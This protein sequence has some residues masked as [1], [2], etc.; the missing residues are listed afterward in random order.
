MAGAADIQVTF[1]AYDAS[2]SDY[3]ITDSASAILGDT[4][5]A[6]D[7]GV[8]T[9]NVDGP[10]GAGVGVQ[11]G[12]LEDVLQLE[13]GMS[14]D[15]IFDVEDSAANIVANADG[16][17]EARNVTV[18]DT[19]NNYVSD[20]S[21]SDAAAIEGINNSGLTTYNILDTAQNLY[22]LEITAQQVQD[23]MEAVTGFG[24][25]VT[26]AQ[27]AQYVGMVP[28][29]SLTN[30]ASN[31]NY[32][33]SDI[34]EYKAA[35][36]TDTASFDVVQAYI[37]N[38]PSSTLEEYTIT[39]DPS[40]ADISISG[41]AEVFKSSDGSGTW[42][43]RVEVGETFVAEDVTQIISEDTTAT[44][45]VS[46][47]TVATY[48]NSATVTTYQ[49]AA[50]FVTG[51]TWDA[52][53]IYTLVPAIAA[54]SDLY[55]G[56]ETEQQIETNYLSAL[57]GSITTFDEFRAVGAH[58]ENTPET[59]DA[60]QYFDTT[61]GVIDAVISNVE[62]S[63]DA[64]V[65]IGE[66]LASYATPVTFDIADDIS[67]VIGS[68][69]QTNGNFGDVRDITINDTANMAQGIQIIDGANSGTIDVNVDDTAGAI[70]NELTEVSG[71]TNLDELTSLTVT[72]GVVDVSS[73]DDLQSVAGYDSGASSYT[74]TDTA[75]AILGDTATVIDDGVSH[76][77]VAGNVGAGVGVQLGQL[78]DA[79][80]E[81]GY[82]ADI[83]FNVVDDANDIAAAL[84][85][86]T[87]G[88]MDNAASMIVSG[89][90][91]TVTEAAD[92]QGVAGYDSGASSYTITDS[93]D[94]VLTASNESSILNDGVSGVVVTDATGAGYVDALDGE[95]LSDLE[96]LLQTATNDSAA[97][98]EFRVEDDAAAIAAVL[99]G[100][101]FALD[102][103]NDLEVTGGAT[104][105]AGAADIQSSGAYDAANSDYTIT[106]TAGAILGDTA[107]AIDDGVS[108]INVAGNVG[109]GVGVQLGQLEDASFETGYSA[110]INFNVVDDAN[111]IAAALSGDTTGAMDNAASMIVS[112]GT[113][114]VTEAADIQGV[115]GYD[116]GASSYTITDTAGA[117]LSASTD[118]LTNDGVSE[119]NVSGVVKAD[120]GASL[121]EL[122]SD[123]NQ[124]EIPEF[125][126]LRMPISE[127]SGTTDIN[128]NVVDDANDIAQVLQEASLNNAEDVDVVG[129]SVSVDS[130][131]DIQ[132][133]TSYDAAN[134]SYTI[135]DTAGAI[136]G[137]TATV[138]DDGVSHINVAGNVGAGVGVQLG[139]L[140]DAS[141]E[142]GYSADI[143]F[144]VV[145]DANDIAAALSGDTTGAM[146]N[147]ASMIVSGGTAT[148]TEAA[149]IQGV[150][151]YDSGAS[152]YTIT[153]SAD[154]VLT[155]SNE[156]S[157]LN[158]GVSG[159]VV[160][161]ATG[162]GYVDALDGEALSDLEGLLQ[163]ATNDSAADIEF[164][165]EDDA[166]AIAAVLNG[167]R[168]ALDG[169]NDLEVTG[170]ATTMAGA[171]DI[172]SSG[173]YDAANS[174]YTITDTA[175][176]IL[177][178]TAT[179]I[180]D[181]VSD[182]TVTNTVDAAQGVQLS[183]LEAQ[184]AV[185]T[186]SAA[187]DVNFNVEDSS[188]VFFTVDNDTTSAIDM[189]G[190]NS[191]VID[192]QGVA[193]GSAEYD[194]LAAQV[195][196]S[197][198]GWIDYAAVKPVISDFQVDTGIYDNDNETADADIVLE[199]KAE[200]GST[201]VIENNGS[202]VSA[203]V[204]ISETLANEA[205]LSESAR[206]GQTNTNY[207][208]DLV[209]YQITFG[210]SLTEGANNIAVTATDGAGN[211][212][213]SDAL[214]VTYDQTNPTTTAI[215]Y[216]AD[217]GVITD[218]NLT[219]KGVVTE[220]SIP[221]FDGSGEIALQL[222]SS[223]GTELPSSV[224]GIH[225]NTSTGAW[226]VTL[227]GDDIRV[228]GQGAGRDIVIRSHDLAGNSSDV[229]VSYNVYA[230]SSL[231]TDN[232]VEYG[233]LGNALLGS[234]ISDGDNSNSFDYDQDGELFV[235]DS[236]G[237]ALL[238][239]Q[240]QPVGE[241][242]LD[243]INFSE[244]TGDVV[245][246]AAAGGGTEAAMAPVIERDAQLSSDIDTGYDV[247]ISGQ[248]NDEL[249]G[250]P[251]VSEIFDAGAGWNRIDAGNSD[252]VNDANTDFIMFESLW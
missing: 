161:D 88:A 180:D 221:D 54:R 170:G 6:I 228:V 173:A 128:F 68:V 205:G 105:M 75:G 100:D 127:A 39:T 243:I 14:S 60:D 43:V 189:T 193:L 210:T 32:T 146:D 59:V 81:T 138:I 145:D 121:D 36:P 53:A 182:I 110:D 56:T 249:F 165:V 22:D 18:Y 91:A 19:V 94:A 69:L 70:L 195:E 157:I 192:S 133:I 219:I 55:G 199:V 196:G 246:N 13:S 62:A 191:V 167:D 139:Q 107:T 143:N 168:F 187:A 10:V 85:G 153:D 171:A 46:V 21:M 214:S 1:W 164:R 233:Q 206:S 40:A 49:V 208:Y 158:D 116:S 5:T 148:V 52:Q 89:G 102:G 250:M 129:G 135:S 124:V 3:T 50:P 41:I 11:L 64:T 97:D 229:T 33:E 177:G 77:N 24:E 252:G 98:I 163:T 12:Q 201:F 118:I 251:T 245:F 30:P 203:S 78:E 238:D 95:A 99:N 35:I 108:H 2:S 190:A 150:A 73:A 224:S 184:L 131:S 236:T 207:E 144:N 169:A 123:L 112:G 181:G 202:V 130:A 101:R 247:I 152:S 87:T 132:D 45:D 61:Y 17:D 34:A 237:A 225:V 220:N 140:E 194:A 84:S 67:N 216:P 111:D 119:V 79:S 155:A 83:N 38:E 234:A 239:T 185:E 104:T 63:D 109:A 217:N 72:A 96:G 209:T 178:D 120:I 183:S 162:A 213:T 65:I 27:L 25:S 4:A 175:G 126:F 204:S 137:D 48:D 235:V 80:F 154:A 240:G 160:T 136:L 20:A 222:F 93:A 31:A 23:Y 92:I 113:A 117:V 47:S 147:A 231:D 223:D 198:S 211:S 186:G 212:A 37:A 122:E 74:I 149:D 76:I 115:A 174:D 57:P 156:S 179:A 218:T 248:G 15:I 58:L 215:L 226:D 151:G 44:V 71:G 166:A 159:V 142:T 90:T 176:A 200:R 9:I 8:S 82:S 86:D 230:T 172:Q 42:T 227:S 188:G 114:T 28:D 125:K 29:T 141:F 242:A 244:L 232:M 66:R 106:D 16:L 51:Q 26:Y 103:A 197:V 241:E 134:S 7:D